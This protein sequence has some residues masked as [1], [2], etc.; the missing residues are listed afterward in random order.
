MIEERLD[1][2]EGLITQ[3]IQMGGENNKSVR[4]IELRMDGVEQRLDGVEQRLDGMGQRLDGV[5][6][7][8]DSVGQRMERMEQRFSA[9][10]ERNEHRHKEVL[11]ELRNT[12]FEIDYLREQSSKHDMEMHVLRESQS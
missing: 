9:E 8:L 12:S 10:Q 1:R 3:L 6:Q 5:E 7:R 11:K 2:I 4:N